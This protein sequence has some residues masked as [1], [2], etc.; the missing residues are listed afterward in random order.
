MK[1]VSSTRRNKKDLEYAPD[2]EEIE[3]KVVIARAS[4]KSDIAMTDLYNKLA[5]EMK[6][7]ECIQIFDP[8]AVMGKKHLYAAYLNSILSFVEH[9]NKT[10]NIGMEMLLFVSFT[11]Q[12]EKA[13]RITGA[14]K[15]KDFILFCSNK[16]VY[17][18]ILST[19]LV[20]CTKYIQ[21]P[22]EKSNAI[23]IIKNDKVDEIDISK[24]LLNKMA[25]L[26]LN[27]K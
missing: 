24:V 27:M 18:K 23:K 9:K 19:N 25:K 17:D 6:K 2:F 16:R 22:N 20:K 14:K 5:K 21:T 8:N 1:K 10:K 13:I 12:I 11:D 15:T 4:A 3:K 26:K 7:S